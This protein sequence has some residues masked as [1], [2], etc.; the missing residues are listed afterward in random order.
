M[1]RRRP[2][3]STALGDLTMGTGSLTTSTRSHANS[4]NTLM[5][6]PEKPTLIS[7]VPN[8]VSPGCAGTLASASAIYST[9]VHATQSG[10]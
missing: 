9:V 7:I 10:F 6:V 5:T 2:A 8:S 1:G 4:T 3:G